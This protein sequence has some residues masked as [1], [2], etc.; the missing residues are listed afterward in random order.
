MALRHLRT[1]IAAQ[2]VRKR[3]GTDLFIRPHDGTQGFLGQYRTVEPL[4]RVLAHIAISAIPVGMFP[5]II[6]QD[7]TTAHVGFRIFLHPAQLLHVDFPL[8]ALLGKLGQ[9][10][11]IAQ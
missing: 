10:H 3:S 5:E 6:Q 2:D 9:L 1:E 11:Q 8:P 7:A 4:R